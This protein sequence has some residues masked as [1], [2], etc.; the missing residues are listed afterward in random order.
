[1]QNKSVTKCT[2]LQVFSK[3]S[4]YGDTEPLIPA[5]LRQKQAEVQGHT[6]LHREFQGSLGKHKEILS[7]ATKNKTPISFKNFQVF[8]DLGG[9]CAARVE[10]RSQHDES[11]LTFSH[12]GPRD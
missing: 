11:V 4:G 8:I 1:M 10:G 2:S 9:V 5:L 7:Q 12:L 3:A 6:G